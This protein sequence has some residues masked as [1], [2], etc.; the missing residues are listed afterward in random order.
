[1]FAP[2]LTSVDDI[3]T[4][5]HA[6]ILFLTYTWLAGSSPI[7]ITA[8]PILL[9]ISKDIDDLFS[10][11]LLPYKV[12]EPNEVILEVK[13][14]NFLPSTIKKVLDT[15]VLFLCHKSF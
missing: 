8:R 10:K 1:M 13:F 9:T 6:F 15:L 14:N 7:K 4:S 2:N 3:P 5:A 11:E 12:L